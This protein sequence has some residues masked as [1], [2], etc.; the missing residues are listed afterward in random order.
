MDEYTD[1]AVEILSELIKIPTVNPPGAEYRRCAEYLYKKMSE[2]GFDVEIIEIPEEYLDKY[3]PYSPQHRGY[4]RLI[5]YAKKGKSGKILHFNGHYD[6]VPPGSGWS[7]DPFTPVVEGDKI[8]GRGSTDMKGGIA[9]TIAALKKIIDQGFSRDMI[10]EA[11]FV[12]DEESGGVG[13]RYYVESVKRVPDYVVIAEPS[14]SSKITIGHKGLVRGVVSVYGKQAHGSVP[15]LGDNAFLK[16]SELVLRF[17]R[18]YTP[19]LESRVTRAPVEDERARH[20]TI[21]L[22]GY[23]E[24]LSRK[25]NIVPGEFVFSIDRRVIPEED[26][27]QVVSELREYMRRASEE[28]SIRHEVKILSAVPPA[29]TPV[30]ARLVRVAE[31][32]VKD[33]LRVQPRITISTGRNDSVYYRSRGSEVITY[34]PGVE[35]VAHM[36]DEYNSIEEIRRSIDVYLCIAN[37]L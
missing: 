10:L 25:D 23:A 14:T 28:T 7:R 36:P 22:G 21:N 6:V 33:V 18:I 13:T 31:K 20:P 26:I 29:L 1:F 9:A 11:L 3:Y 4:P 8:Y 27:D 2:I 15:W 32:C 19:L 12:P 17:M 16:A 37:S 34:G 30:D 5:V 24:S 35:S